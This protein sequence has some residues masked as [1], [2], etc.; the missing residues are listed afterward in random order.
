MAAWNRDPGDAAI[1]TLR[2]ARSLRVLRRMNF[3]V[4]LLVMV[5]NE[6]NSR[7]LHIPNLLTLPFASSSFVPLT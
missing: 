5:F 6:P 7:L 2:D 1:R 4:L 3:V